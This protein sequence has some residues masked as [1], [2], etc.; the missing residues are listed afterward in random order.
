MTWTRLRIRSVRRA[1][2]RD[3]WL[4]SLTDSTCCQYSLDDVD[5]GRGTKERLLPMSVPQHAAAQFRRKS[6]SS[7][8]IATKLS[9]ANA[10]KP[11]CTAVARASYFLRFFF[12]ACFAAHSSRPFFCLWYPYATSSFFGKIYFNTKLKSPSYFLSCVHLSPPFFLSLSPP[13]PP[14]PLFLFLCVGGMP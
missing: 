1:E 4:W 8:P 11:S 3:N 5:V 9:K 13:P 2:L 10:L 7:E 14:S 12:S 6:T